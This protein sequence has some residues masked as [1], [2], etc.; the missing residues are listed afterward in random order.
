[1]GTTTAADTTAVPHTTTTAAA[2]TTTTP[3]SPP[4]SLATISLAPTAPE[5]SEKEQMFE[6][7]FRTY[8]KRRGNKGK[9]GTSSIC[10]AWGGF[11]V[12]SNCVD[13]VVPTAE[14]VCGAL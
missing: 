7:G 11:C 12:P 3:T 4:T 6:L 8:C 13:A 5:P 2:T 1:M 9:C 10:V 14:S